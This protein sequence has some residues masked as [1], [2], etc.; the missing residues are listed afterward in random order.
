MIVHL[1]DGT[2]EIFRQYY[3]PRPGHLDSAGVEIGATRG[4]VQS[5]FA[6]LQDKDIRGVI[7][8]VQPHI[9]HWFVSGIDTPR[10]A[11]AELLDEQLAKAGITRAVT[12]CASVAVACEQACDLATEDDRILVF[13]SFYTVAAAMRWRAQRGSKSGGEKT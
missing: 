6:M 9:D 1:V 7:D 2:Y 10:G 11:G 13:G 5:V 8:A 12:R 3:A 4:V